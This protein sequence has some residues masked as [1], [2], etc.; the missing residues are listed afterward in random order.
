LTN[1][2][3]PPITAGRLPTTNAQLQVTH[4][5]QEAKRL[6]ACSFLLAGRIAGLLKL[7]QG[8]AGGTYVQPPE[9]LEP[10]KRLAL[11][12]AYLHHVLQWPGEI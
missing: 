12:H 9:R 5:T 4:H 6:R 2:L 11:K 3:T 1:S 8:G 7:G 10:G